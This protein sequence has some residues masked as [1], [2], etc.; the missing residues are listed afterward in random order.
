MV[1]TS[2]RPYRGQRDGI[3]RDNVDRVLQF[4]AKGVGHADVSSSHRPIT[5]PA[6]QQGGT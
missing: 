1:T 4:L 5:H 3:A 2:R 6:L